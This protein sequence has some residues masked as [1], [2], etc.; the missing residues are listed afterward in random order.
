MFKRIIGIGSPF[1]QDRIGIEVIEQL[2]STALSN[3]VE[4]IAL[5]RPGLALIDYFNVDSLLLVDAVRSSEL[6]QTLPGSLE[7]VG[8]D[9]LIENKLKFSTHNAGVADAI[10]LAKTLNAL[11]ARL[12][13]LGINIEVGTENEIPKDWIESAKSKVLSLLEV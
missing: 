3:A 7:V 10:A 6:S 5:D 4:L 11:P 9:A 12:L 1:A 8:V 2:Q 13:I